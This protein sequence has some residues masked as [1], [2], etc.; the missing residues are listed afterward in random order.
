MQSPLWVEFDTVELYINNVP[1]PFDDD[2]DPATTATVP[3]DP[4]RGL[5]QRGQLQ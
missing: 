5:D 2:G 4:E 3:G 1:V